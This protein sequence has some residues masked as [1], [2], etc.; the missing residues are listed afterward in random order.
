VKDEFDAKRDKLASQHQDTREV[1]RTTSMENQQAIARLEDQHSRLLGDTRRVLTSLASHANNPPAVR[2]QRV[3]TAAD[4]DTN[5]ILRSYDVEIFLFQHRWVA[6]NHPS[7]MCGVDEL[8]NTITAPS[9]S[10]TSPSISVNAL[11]IHL[12]DLAMAAPILFQNIYER[13][14]LL[15]T[16]LLGGGD[17]LQSIT[18]EEYKLKIKSCND[19]L[20]QGLL[21]SN[22]KQLLVR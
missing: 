22:H 3:L 13:A 7:N 19:A 6:S 11:I 20:V 8:F 2:K 21:L 14:T 16:K 15:F 18:K 17:D 12:N 5:N 1:Y 10:T 9:S 4:A